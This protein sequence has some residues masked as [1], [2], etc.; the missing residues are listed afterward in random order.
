M[1]RLRARGAAVVALGPL[2]ERAPR[3]AGPPW[4]TVCPFR[5]GEPVSTLL[6]TLRAA[7]GGRPLTEVPTDGEASSGRGGGPFLTPREAE[8]LGLYASGEKAD[9]VARLLG[10]TRETVLDHIRRIRAKYALA[11]RP[12]HT[13]VD[14]YRRAV[15][16]G[17]LPAPR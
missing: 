17:L 9:R 14:L 8:V 1:A 6:D 3:T 13:K 5:G 4:F 16:D 11:D 7:A 15:E 12:A 2:P 10:V